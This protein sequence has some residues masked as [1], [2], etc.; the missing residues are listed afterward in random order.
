MKGRHYLVS[1]DESGG[2]AGTGGLAAACARGASAFGYPNIIDI[3]D[4]KNPN[5]VAKLMLQ[6]ND[7]AHCRLLD[8]PKDSDGAAPVYNVERCVPDRDNDPRMLACTFQNAGLRVFDIRD[9]SRPL[10]IAYYKPPAPRTAALPGSGS[11]SKGVDRTYDR[12]AGYPHFNKVAP[13]KA[14]VKDAGRPQMELWIS[15]DGNGFQVLRFTDNFRA[16]HPELF[17][18]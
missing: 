16:Q 9:L 7:P 13:A 14:N 2:A 1:T 11:W 17:E 3:S 4:E 18:D 12:I 8:E 5:I 15:S 10:E 6:V